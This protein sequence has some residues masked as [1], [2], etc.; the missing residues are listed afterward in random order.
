MRC[1]PT[2]VLVHPFADRSEQVVAGR[3]QR[4]VL[5]E[6]PVVAVGRA[7]DHGQ[8]LVDEER[9]ALDHFLIF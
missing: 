8:A 5:L 4:I 7:T 3:L 2:V 1:S 6:V 9:D